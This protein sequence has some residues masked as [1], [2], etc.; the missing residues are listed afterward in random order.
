MK[1]Y[2]FLISI[3]ISLSLNAQH[4]E[5][6]PY[7]DFLKTQNTSAKDYLISLFDRYD[8]V[9][10]SERIHLELTQYELLRSVFSDPRFQ[11]KSGHIFMEMGG[12]NFDKPINDYL[13]ADNLSE[14]ESR[15]RAIDIQ[16]NSTWYPL[17]QRYNYHHLLTGL[18]RINSGLSKDI[19]LSLHPTDIDVNWSKILTK[20]DVV[21]NI[22]NKESMLGRDSVMA[23][24]ITA[25]IK[26]LEA[27]GEKR[28]KYFVILNSAH[29]MKH[30]YNLMGFSV[31]PA[32]A[33]LS[34]NFP[35]K[36]A[37]VL[38]NSEAIGNLTSTTK[39]G[40]FPPI[41]NG[42]W[43][44]AFHRLGKDDLGF[45]LDKSPIADSLFQNM[46]L[47]EKGVTNRQ[48]YTGYVYYRHYPNFVNVNGVDGLIDEE[49][50]IELARRS[51]IFYKPST[52]S[53]EELYANFY[54]NFGRK[55]STVPEFVVEYWQKVMQWNEKPNEE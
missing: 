50:K 48:A 32:G 53:K 3:C 45:D 54:N 31:K 13:H 17:W 40:F 11:E 16:R 10:F 55:N 29:A 37:N 21:K 42:K 46:P 6:K 22:R 24:N 26:Q 27:K 9:I 33:F 28:Q 23:V 47:V 1:K 2:V 39:L 41:L 49:F 4:S 8:I 7:V 36:V 44:A 19:K 25:K 5:I 38:L 43:D 18:Y 35:G 34:E 52:I 30:D 14:D 15:K 12:S 20:E 51:A